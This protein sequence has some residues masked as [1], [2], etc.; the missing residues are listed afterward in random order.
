MKAMIL[1]AGVG[2][3]LDP[4][5]R[6]IP[7]P[8]VPI[9]NKPVMEHIIVNLVRHGFTDIMVNLFHLG[10][11]I[12]DYFRDGKQW[13]AGIRYSKEPKLMG[14]AG[15]VKTVADFFNGETFVVI[16]GD[17][18]TDVD[19]T[20]GIE[21]HRKKQALATIGLSL[22]NDPSEYGVVV[23]ND[24]GRITKFVE[25]PKGGA[26]FSNAANTGIYFFEPEILDLIPHRTFYDFGSQLFPLLVGLKPFYGY[27][28][29]GYWRDIGGLAQYRQSHY[30]ALARIIE[31]D[32][33]GV[34]RKDGVWLG[35][36][37]D[38]D[39]SAKVEGPALIG[40][41]CRIEADASV[42][43]NSILGRGCVVEIGATVRESILWDGAC[44]MRNTHIER[45][46]VGNNC[47]VRSNAAVFDGVI[48]DPHAHS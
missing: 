24:D 38:I 4:L 5:T 31:I 10:E 6:N 37:V 13:G 9:A 14:T 11:Q 19:L 43:A 30:D 40:P 7:K 20:K 27:L 28:T 16:G 47:Q 41:G 3:R 44:V 2:S 34:R 33:D 45:C 15:S 8:M 36:G 32:I 46:V 25:K 12:E 21:F 17:D 29:A 1:A 26:F 39:K 23:M 42:G 18:L 35:D 48:V 22:V